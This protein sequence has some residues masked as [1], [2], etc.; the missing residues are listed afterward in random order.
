MYESFPIHTRS[1]T[2]V[3]GGFWS[4]EMGPHPDS[5]GKG[6]RHRSGA[7]RRAARI[8][9]GIRL[10]G[11]PIRLKSCGVL[12]SFFYFPDPGNGLGLQLMSGDA[13]CAF[14]SQ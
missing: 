8:Q 3:I 4:R 6:R 2:D 9:S 7:R 5:T 12:A 10:L 11:M 14:G 1:R 13:E